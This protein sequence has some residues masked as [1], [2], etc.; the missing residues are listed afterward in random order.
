MFFFL[1][2]MCALTIYQVNF[3]VNALVIIQNFRQI[4]FFEMLKPDKILPLI[5][6]KISVS[7]LLNL[8]YKEVL[9]ED[10]SFE[11]NGIESSNCLVNLRIYLFILIG[12]IFILMIFLLIA[13]VFKNLREKIIEKI[14]KIITGFIWNNS[15]KS[16]LIAY[17][18][19][20]IAVT[21][22]IAL[23]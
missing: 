2:I 4:I 17:L 13:A 21:G 14:K 7:E 16:L 18:P 10:K 23:Q 3:P 19:Q 11:E 6:I 9:L 5:G 8:N 15:I 12:F 1:Q 20:C 22:A